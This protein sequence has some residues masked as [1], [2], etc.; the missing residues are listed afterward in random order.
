MNIYAAASIFAL[1]IAMY[2]VIS[3][4]FT[5]LFRLVGLPEEKARFQVV[6]LLTGCGFTTRDSEMVLAT[7]S[8][9]RMARL[10]MLFGYLFNITFVS[11]MVNF[12]ISMQPIQV[13]ESV[14]SLLIPLVAICTV[15]AFVRV[16]RIRKVLDRLIAGLASKFARQSRH[17]SVLLI[18]Q[19]GKEC[20]AQVHLHYV[21]TA[22]QDKP[23]AET[24]LKSE[25]NLLILSVEREDGTTEPA[26]AD[27]VFSPGDR[28][29]IFGD[30]NQ[31]C[32]GFEARTQFVDEVREVPFGE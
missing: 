26:Q 4:V 8:R 32:Q 2:W 19:L 30:Y 27:T 25:R 15:F 31:I 24:E 6:S 23:L 28:L 3:E 14:T 20:I 1:L 18:D 17:N 5:V 10:T 13:K 22:L 21:P 29:T 11:A 7:R 12:F 16:Q 9:R